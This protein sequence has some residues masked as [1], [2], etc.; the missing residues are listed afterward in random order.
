MKNKSLSDAVNSP[1]KNNIK[2]KS[3]KIAMHTINK[4]KST[5]Q[6]NA[7]ASGVILI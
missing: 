6:A 7:L 4:S 2:D 3:R 1:A 5:S